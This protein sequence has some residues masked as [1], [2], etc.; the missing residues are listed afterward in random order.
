MFNS[1]FHHLYAR[2]D[3]DCILV[4]EVVNYFRDAMQYAILG[5]EVHQDYNHPQSSGENVIKQ[6]QIGVASHI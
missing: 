6:L 5:C 3:I 4:L 1:S 2:F